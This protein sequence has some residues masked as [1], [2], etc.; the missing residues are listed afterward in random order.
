[1]KKAAVSKPAPKKAA[2][3]TSSSTSTVDKTVPK[4]PV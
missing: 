1:V 3:S 4:K 2:V